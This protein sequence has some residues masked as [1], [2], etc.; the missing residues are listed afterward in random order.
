MG[1]IRNLSASLFGRK[2]QTNDEAFAYAAEFLTGRLVKDN[3]VIGHVISQRRDA[4]SD[5]T[6]S[7]RLATDLGIVT[8]DSCST[9]LMNHMREQAN[10][11]KKPVIPGDL[12][13]VQVQ[14]FSEDVP[15]ESG[16]NQ[17][18]IVTKLKPILHLSKDAFVTDFP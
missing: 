8:T 10:L 7:V 14:F 18:T 12:V 3:G 13:L 6:W 16:V 2:F 11:A 15:P 17:F 9:F 4:F 1:N 5:D